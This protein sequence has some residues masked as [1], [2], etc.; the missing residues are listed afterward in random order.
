[1]SSADDRTMRGG[2][3]QGL[4]PGYEDRRINVTS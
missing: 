3:E 1:M 2:H 4:E